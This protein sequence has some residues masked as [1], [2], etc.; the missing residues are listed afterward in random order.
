MN[1]ITQVGVIGLG[2]IGKPIA[3]R[4]L[5]ARF[6]VAVHDV[7]RE[8]VAETKTAGARAC[9]HSRMCGEQGPHWSRRAMQTRRGKSART[10]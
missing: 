8:P 10:V 1:A 4:L 3:D 2:N 6:Q 7:R 5:K 9:A